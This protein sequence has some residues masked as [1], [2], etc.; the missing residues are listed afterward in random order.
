MTR[1]DAENLGQ[2]STV[3]WTDP[4]GSRCSA[5]ITI[6]HIE[7]VEDMAKIVDKDGNYLECFVSELS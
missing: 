6:Q 3:Y 2:N 1:K 4:D 5:F 7:V